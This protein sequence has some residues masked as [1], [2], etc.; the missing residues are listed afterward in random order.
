MILLK[1]AFKISLAGLA[2]ALFLLACTPPLSPPA[3]STPLIIKIGSPTKVTNTQIPLQ[4]RTETPQPM[5]TPDIWKIQKCR[6]F[7]SI[8]NDHTMIWTYTGDIEK[9]GQVD[10]LLSFSKNNEIRGFL[11]D[12]G[13]M[14]EYKVTGCVED[15]AIKIWLQQGEMV[16]AIIQ[17]EFPVTDPRGYYS[18]DKK[19]SFPIITGTLIDKSNAETLAIYLRSG[20][21]NGG[22]MEQ[23]FKLEGVQDDEIILNASQEFI[24]AVDNNERNLIVAMIE[25]PIECEIGA[26]RQKF[27]TPDAFLASYDVIFENGFKERLARAFPNYLTAY[28]GDIG[29]IG[30]YVYGGGSIRFNGQGKIVGIYNWQKPIYTPTP[31][32]NP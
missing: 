31:S 4:P 17:G 16:D 21:A 28:S 24:T 13:R 27:D 26:K 20:M 32:L 6:K 23:R 22:T 10:M 7:S 1:K 8:V 29:G 5:T 14:R 15:R 19:L 3:E 2:V 18:P 30:L 9:Y 11:F 12:F 25:F